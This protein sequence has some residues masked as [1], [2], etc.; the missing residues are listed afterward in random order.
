MSQRTVNTA[1]TDSETEDESLLLAES[2]PIS[3]LTGFFRK[4]MV[5]GPHETGAL[6]SGGNILRELEQ[7]SHKVGWSFLGWGGGKK[8][9]VKMNKAPFRLRLLFSNLLS[10]GYESLDGMI[11]VTASVTSSG[12][13]YSSVV[14]GRSSVTSAEVAST[15]AASVD[16]LVQVKVTE[17]DGQGLRH[18]SSVQNRL[19]AELEPQLRGALGERGLTLESVD[20][21]AFNNPDEGD[22]LLEGLS[23]VDRLIAEGVKPGRED[24]QGLLDRLRNT[25]LATKEMGERA[26]LLFDGGTDGAFFS[27]MKDISVSSTRRLEAKL[28]DKSERLAKKVGSDDD[29]P[30]ETPS[31]GGLSADKVLGF[32]VPTAA[33]AGIIYGVIPD[34]AGGIFGLVAGLAAAAVF[35]VGHI[36]IRA[37]RLLNRPKKEEIVIRLDK[38]VKRNSMKTDDLIRRQMGREFTNT[39][40]DVKSAKL[41][42]HQQG[43]KAVADALASIEN[44]MDLMRTEVESA[45]AASSIVSVKNFPTQRIYRMVRFEEE[46]LRHA[47]DLSIRSHAIKES[48]DDEAVNELRLGLDEFHLKFTK[49]LGL[50]EGFREL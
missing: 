42:A 7:G 46:L 6:V 29:S 25:G 10:K 3:D 47:R 20:L 49:R 32:L 36:I 24:I 23:E 39:L 34:T 12:H 4:T 21:V 9:A 37:K 15:I 2:T 1:V 5:V 35:L 48:L 16:D 19:A 33:L 13:F 8:Q 27:V 11:Y 14:R 40:E 18:D 38:W 28:L 44:Q 22:E 45:P 30:T 17:N 50:L 41:A 26:Q 31:G 43:K